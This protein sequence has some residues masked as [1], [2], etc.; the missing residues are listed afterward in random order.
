MLLEFG[1]HPKTLL[2]CEVAELGEKHARLGKLIRAH[3]GPFHLE[4]DPVEAETESDSR[5]RLATEILDKIVVP[6]SSTERIF[7]S[8]T[9]SRP[10]F[11]HGPRVVVET[12]DE[13]RVDRIRQFEFIEVFKKRFEMGATFVIEEVEG[14]RGLRGQLYTLVFL[15]VEDAHRIGHESF[16]TLLHE[17][18]TIYA[19]S[20]NYALS[21]PPKNLGYVVPPVPALYWADTRRITSEFFKNKIQ[22]NVEHPRI[23]DMNT[24]T[25]YA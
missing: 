22:F 13:T 9:V 16:T 12:P 1:E 8:L 19:G 14:L 15:A 18:D 23:G 24:L 6:A 7:L 10:N 11:E 5:R 20:N 3:L 4:H 25:L 17:V 2:L 21:T